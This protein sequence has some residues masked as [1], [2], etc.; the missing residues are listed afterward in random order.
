MPAV[1]AYFGKGLDPFPV[2]GMATFAAGKSVLPF[3]RGKVIFAL[4]RGIKGF[5][6]FN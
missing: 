1:F 4:F 3:I 2:L 5:S 6:K